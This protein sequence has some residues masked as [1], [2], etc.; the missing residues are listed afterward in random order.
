MQRGHN[1]ANHDFSIADLTVIHHGPC[2]E[3]P[4][5]TRNCLRVT[6]ARLSQEAILSKFPN[7]TPKPS[8]ASLLDSRNP[9]GSLLSGFFLLAAPSEVRVLHHQGVLQPDDLLIDTLPFD[10][11]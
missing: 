1:I 6:P 11:L 7:S 3:V 10:I 8:Q 2:E 9:K 4:N 5:L